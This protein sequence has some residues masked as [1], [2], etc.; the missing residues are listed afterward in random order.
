MNRT[1]KTC[2]T[3]F[4]I[5]KWQ[6]GKQYCNDGCKPTFRPNRGKPRGRPKNEWKDVFDKYGI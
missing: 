4:E 2:G 5:N 1:C 6:K 3:V